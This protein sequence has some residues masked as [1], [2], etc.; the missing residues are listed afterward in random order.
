[1]TLIAWGGNHAPPRE[2]QQLAH[3][4]TGAVNRFQYLQQVR[5]GGL[6]PRELEHRQLCEASNRRQHVVE[7]VRNPACQPPD[8]F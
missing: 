4:L 7:V 1:L 6:V 3:Q 2:R 5:A 8:A